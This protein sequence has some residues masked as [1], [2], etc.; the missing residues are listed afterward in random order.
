[1][2]YIANFGAFFVQKV[3]NLKFAAQRAAILD[4]AVN[5]LWEDG[6]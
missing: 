1:M 6:T 5:E 4:S 3:E 2:H